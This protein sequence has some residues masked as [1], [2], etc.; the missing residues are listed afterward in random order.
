ML[1]SVSFPYWKMEKYTL[2][3]ILYYFLCKS[4]VKR[5]SFLFYLTIHIIYLLVSLTMAESA[6]VALCSGRSTPSPAHTV[7][8]RKQP[9]EWEGQQERQAFQHRNVFQTTSFPSQYAVPFWQTLT[10]VQALQYS[11]NRMPRGNFPPHFKKKK[12]RKKQPNSPEN[13]WHC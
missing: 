6:F 11:K 3:R 10:S 13:S 12:R 5:H 7:S 8:K 2:F 1:F 9:G 4:T